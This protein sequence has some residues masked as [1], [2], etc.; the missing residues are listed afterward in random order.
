MRFVFVSFSATSIKHQCEIFYLL[1][2][3]KK[4][5]RVT[6]TAM[7]NPNETFTWKETKSL[8]CFFVIHCI[9]FSLFV[10]F[11]VCLC[12]FLFD[13]KHRLNKRFC[14]IFSQIEIFVLSFVFYAISIRPSGFLCSQ[15]TIIS[16][17]LNMWSHN[18]VF[19]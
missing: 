17:S 4:K 10:Y 9:V 12:F 13:L 3:R 18:Q 14:A 16:L 15:N 19:V 1:L 5:R 11:R 8:D 2:N 6:Y 7:E